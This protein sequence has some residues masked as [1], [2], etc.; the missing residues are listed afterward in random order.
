MRRHE[1]AYPPCIGSDTHRPRVPLARSR[2]PVSFFV[3]VGLNLGMITLEFIEMQLT[4]R[5]GGKQTPWDRFWFGQVRQG[6][7]NPRDATLRP[8]KRAQTG[9]CPCP[10]ADVMRRR[11][12]P[13]RRARTTTPSTRRASSSSS[14]L[15]S[16]WPSF[17]WCSITGMVNGPKQGSI[18]RRGRRA[19]STSRDL[20]TL[21]SA[22][23][24]DHAARAPSLPVAALS[25]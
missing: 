18:A 8:R 6:R 19:T 21:W 11:S 24:H 20:K 14:I 9:P 2:R 15:S 7:S 17:L 25:L 12:G 16:T 3:A 23:R 4:R 13:M 22:R 5:H 10:R 1:I